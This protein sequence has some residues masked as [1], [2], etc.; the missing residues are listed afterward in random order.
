MIWN[1]LARASS[2]SSSSSSGGL[3]GSMGT[4][5]FGVLMI[6]ALVAIWW[7]GKKSQKKREEEINKTLDAIK[8]GNKVKTIGGICGIVVEVCPDD[9]TFILETGSETTGKSYMK[10]DKKA[11]YTTD[12]VAAPVEEVPALEEATEEPFEEG[13]PVEET[14]ETPVGEVA[15]ETNDEE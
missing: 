13:A 10:F 9:D 15:E 6:G 3:K 14:V 12:A 1:L 7:F 8:P 2:S 5:V 11:V 4:I